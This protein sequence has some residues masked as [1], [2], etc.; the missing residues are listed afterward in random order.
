MEKISLRNIYFAVYLQS[1]LRAIS[2]Q[3]RSVVMYYWS[4]AL[5]SPLMI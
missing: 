4:T 1:Y 2:V 3:G 5:V